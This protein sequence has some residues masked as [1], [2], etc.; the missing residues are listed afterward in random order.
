MKRFAFIIVCFFAVQQLNAQTPTVPKDTVKRLNEVEIK[1]R[2]PLVT[3]K[4]D[5]FIVNI[6]NSALADGYN[7]LEVLQKSPGIWVSPD[8]GIRINGNQSVMVMIN[9]VV[10]RMSGQELAEYLKSLRSENISKIEVIANPPAEYEASS[11]GGIIHIILKKA[12]EQ[13]ISGTLSAQFR[14]QGNRPYIGGGASL[15]YKFKRWY[16]FGGYNPSKDQSQYRG[17]STTD[18]PDGSRFSSTGLRNNNNTR[19]QYRAGAVYDFSPQQSLTLQHNGT[20]TDLIQSFSSNISYNQVTGKAH[21]DWV[22]HPRLSS[23]TATYVW[24]TDTLGS[25][26][27]VIGDY[28][29]NRKTEVTTLNSEYSDASLSGTFRTNTPSTTDM[30]S[31]QADYSHAFTAKSTA[32]TGLKYV[33]TDRR[34][35]L[36]AEDEAAG[37]WIKDIAGSNDFA[38]NEHLLM[39]YGTFETRLKKTSVKAGLRGEQ[40]YSKGRSLTN[41]ST[42]RRDYFGWFPS[43]FIDHTLAQE[44]GNSARL[45]YSRRVGRPAYNDLNPYRLQVNDFEIVTGNP[46]LL[47]QYTHVVQAGVTLRHKFNADL[48]YRHTTN[49]IAQTALTL[50]DNIIE[51]KS[52]NFPKNV[53]YGVSANISV[54]LLK[55]W[56]AE[57]GLL[58]YHAKA[59]FEDLEIDRTSMVLK[60]M[61]TYKWNKVADFDLY[62]EYTSPYTTANSRQSEIFYMDLGAS[63]A[64]LKKKGRIRLYFA[65]VF[66]T[67][68]EKTITEYKG[69]RIN[70]YQ[71]RP[72]RAVM[73]AFSWNF[74]KG[75][76]FTKKK[77]D[78]NNTDEKSRM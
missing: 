12:R 11:S 78:T 13:G 45:N 5:R 69:T 49:Y 25:S 71:K 32:R 68:R 62:A 41:G 75:K 34:N 23:S 28:T 35:N 7:A 36:L 17:H 33:R 29:R 26:L 59:D 31:A 70:F 22:R 44:K 8:G 53:E 61:Q 20:A 60:T 67:S 21:T 39:F 16:L 27:K 47:P 77:I 51:Y 56:E 65:D 66:N 1:A 30:Y 18:Y 2:K 10:Q 24:K 6:E 74:S 46:D 50:D 54:P 15:D 76:L 48:H 64:I 40:T 9:D 3:R 42:I 73:L 57:N 52:K 14:Q 38:Y 43:V 19:Q 72:T 63:R 4:A 58:L 37:E 55:G